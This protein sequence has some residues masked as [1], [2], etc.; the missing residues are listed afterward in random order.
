MSRSPVSGELR[1]R[2]ALRET[3]KALGI[4]E[5]EDTAVHQGYPLLRLRM[6]HKPDHLA[7][8]SP[9]AAGAAGQSRAAAHPY[10]DRT[11]ESGVPV[12]APHPCGLVVSPGP[13]T[14]MIPL[15]RGDKGYERNSV[16]D[17][18]RERRRG[19]SK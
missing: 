19:S 18:M 11:E 17:V 5:G 3:A 4:R 14:D 9:R 7:K 12:S 15:E 8:V 16:V 1:A 6:S 13:I 10:C 2:S